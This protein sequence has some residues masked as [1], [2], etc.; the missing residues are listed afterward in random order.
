M[1]LTTKKKE[2]IEVDA[3]N[4]LK[5]DKDSIYRSKRSLKTDKVNKKQKSRK[6][7]FH[8]SSTMFQW[9]FSFE[10][11]QQDRTVTDHL[12]F[13]FSVNKSQQH[14][15][16]S[17]SEVNINAVNH[18]AWTQQHYFLNTRQQGF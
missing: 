1:K 2:I 16:L 14:K 3:A 4:L 6:S 17:V 9:N 10:I 5:T 13:N 11:Q 8:L 15:E 18:K 7:D 12:F